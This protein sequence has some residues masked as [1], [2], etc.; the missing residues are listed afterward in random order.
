MKI[1]QDTS[2]LPYN[3]FGIDVNAEYIIEYDSVEDL[4]NVLD[5]DVVVQSKNILPVGSGSNLLFLRDFKGVILHSKI[6]HILTVDES[7]EVIYIEAGSG[8]VW[9]DFVKFCVDNNY[10]GIENL[11]LIPGE[12]GASAVQNIGAY[13]VEVK[14]VIFQVN[15]LEISTRN[16]QHFT[17]N[18]C[19][20]GYRNSIFKNNKKGQYIVTSV[21]FKLSKK[22]V[23]CLNYQHL[24]EEVIAFGGISLGNIRNTIISIR[25][26]KLPNPAQIG[27]A[28]SFFMNPVVASFQFDILKDR[29]P[30]I[31][32]YR[33]SETEIK[34]PAAWLIEQCGWKGKVLGNAGVHE[35][36]A[37]VLINAGNASG[38]E[39]ATLATKIQ[40]SVKNK[41]GIS[42]QPEVIYI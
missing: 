25:E 36:Q 13:G 26:R 20:Y 37:L 40:D 41:F 29:F 16:T 14:D 15:C 33:I 1:F 42:L 11:S 3:T 8:V 2:L 27:N 18:D 31:P 30:L 10:Y 24:E 7:E 35:K 19:N 9:D 5:L 6:N 28:G 34:I 12:V 17:V 22:E 21:V 32:F 23:Y 39:I 4:K 38:I